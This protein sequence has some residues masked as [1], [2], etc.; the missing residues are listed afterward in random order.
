MK[1]P[2]TSENYSLSSQYVNLSEK[3]IVLRCQAGDQEAFNVLI[4]RYENRVLNLA[5][6]YL[7]DYHQALDEAQEVFLKVFKNI[8]SF[9]GKS[10]FGTW[11]Y[12]VTTN[13]CFSVLDKKKRGISGAA[14]SLDA[15][16][17]NNMQ[18]VIKD[19]KAPAPDADMHSEEHREKLRAA[20]HKLPADQQQAIVLCHYEELNYVEIA[21][22]MGVPV[23]TISS[24]LYRARQKLKKI[25]AQKGGERK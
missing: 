2:T 7:R 11:L 8:K 23:S 14:V 16:L 19:H 1:S 18:G 3:E 22:V 13:H 17:E 24:C 25:L 15:A 4:S 20:I 9:Q 10:A 6:K 12:S 5:L 21:E